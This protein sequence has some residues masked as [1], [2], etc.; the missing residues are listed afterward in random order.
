MR[1]QRR[2]V[3]EGR[4]EIESSDKLKRKQDEKIEKE[5]IH[6]HIPSI[7]RDHAIPPIR[8]PNL[9]NQVN[10]PTIHANKHLRAF[11]KGTWLRTPPR[12]SLSVGKAKKE[13]KKKEK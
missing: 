5:Y 1:S 2:E 8:P 13:K 3:G 10:Q 7:L 12:N 9:Q 11:P 6:T 4:R